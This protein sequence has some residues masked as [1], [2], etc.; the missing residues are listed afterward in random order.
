MSLAR[1]RTGESDAEGKGGDGCVRWRKADTEA[2]AGG[3][4]LKANKARGSRGRTM[5]AIRLFQ[6]RPGQVRT[7]VRLPGDPFQYGIRA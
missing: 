4:C 5:H 2:N 3:A 7:A 1:Q 6:L